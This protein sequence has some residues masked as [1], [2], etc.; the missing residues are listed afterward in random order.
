MAETDRELLELAAKA[1][2][3][4][5]MVYRDDVPYVSSNLSGDDFVAW[6][7]RDDD[8]DA[9][10]LATAIPACI[11]IDKDMGWCGVHLNGERG[12]YDFVEHFGDDAA[13]ATRRAIFRAAVEIGKAMP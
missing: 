10:R 13:D 9:L 8:G 12:K 5:R 3:Y 1:A 11:V 7:P 4:V 6:N 2:G